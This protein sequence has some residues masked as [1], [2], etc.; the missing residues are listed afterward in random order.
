MTIFGSIN[1]AMFDWPWSM[2]HFMSGALIG[3]VATWWTITRRSRVFWWLGPS[4]L[5]I[6]EIYERMMHYLDVHH[7][8][9]IAAFKT[10]VDNFA[11]APE[12]KLNT[13]GDLVIGTVGLLVGRSIVVYIRRRFRT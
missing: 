10:A 2:I 11:F 6:W 7:H 9:A 3:L 4:L 8:A 1:I 5:V 13:F 12:T